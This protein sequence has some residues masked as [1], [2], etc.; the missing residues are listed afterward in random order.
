MPLC[1]YQTVLLKSLIHTQPYT[2][3]YPFSHNVFIS[4]TNLNIYLCLSYMPSISYL[5]T[6]LPCAL[7]LR[8]RSDGKL[9]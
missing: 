5:S 7:N 6:L 9:F 8:S 3:K 1:R 4:L 2:F